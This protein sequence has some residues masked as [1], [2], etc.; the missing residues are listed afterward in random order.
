MKRGQCFGSVI[1]VL[2][3]CM[4]GGAFSVSAQNTLSLNVG[5]ATHTISKALYG[6]L[7]ENYGRCIYNG[8]FVGTSSP[9]PNTAGMRNDVIEGFKEAGIGCIEW[10]GGCF[11]DKYHWQD[12]IG[13][14]SS[15]PGGEMQNGLGTPEFFM[16]CSLTNAYAYPT[17]NIQSGSSAEMNAWLNYIHDVPGWWSN[18]P[19]WK[20]GNE[21]WNPCGN[22]TQSQYQTKFDQW[23][24]KA[25]LIWIQ[26][27]KKSLMKR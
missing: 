17:A 26:K 15:R 7:M 24:M 2:I 4:L 18:M 12:G 20:I 13:A 9:I 8:V 16:L 25:W 27:S 11:A 14:Q 19:F 10:P 22:M 6:V 1:N 3:A 5:G 21:E 23:S